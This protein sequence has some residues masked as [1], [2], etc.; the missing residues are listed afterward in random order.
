[1]NNNGA[2]VINKNENINNVQN[3]F[4]HYPNNNSITFSNNNS[5][6]HRSFD[7]RAIAALSQLNTNSNIN[8][9]NNNSFTAQ[10][11]SAVTFPAGKYI[12]PFHFL[13]PA[14]LP[15][16]YSTGMCVKNKQYSNSQARLYYYVK[17]RVISSDSASLL[18]KTSSAL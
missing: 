3:S 12:Y 7:V 13:L 16:S 5:F 17:V 9:I 6:M 11:H 1:M 15:P 18:K 2:N 8:N 10:C 4:F 14:G